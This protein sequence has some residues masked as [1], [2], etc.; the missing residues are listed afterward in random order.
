MVNACAA[1]GVAKATF[2]RSLKS[3]KEPEKK[4]RPAPRRK[5]SDLERANILTVL[6]SE[7]FVDLA[8]T[9]VYATLLD[10]G[11]YLCSVSTMYRI[12]RNAGEVLERRHQRRHRQY[13][14]PE[15]LATAPNQVYSWDITKVRGPEKL[16]SFHLYVVIDI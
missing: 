10:E 4:T 11:T 16:I 5:L 2:Y 6:N 7:R 12:L 15:L 9:Q 8:P 3:R 14:K 1:L 13:Q